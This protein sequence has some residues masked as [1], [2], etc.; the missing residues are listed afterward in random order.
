M[1]PKIRS[2]EEGR[3]ADLARDVWKPQIFGLR[4]EDG[5]GVNQEKRG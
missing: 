4:C 5:T 1:V 2:W 3:V